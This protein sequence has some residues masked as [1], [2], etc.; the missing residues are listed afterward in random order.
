MAL[1]L[2][3]RM[4][5]RS[6]IGVSPKLTFLIGARVHWLQALH[7]WRFFFLGSD[8]SLGDQQ[9]VGERHL[10]LRFAEILELARPCL[11]STTGHYRVEQIALV[12]LLIVEKNVCATG[13]GSAM[14]VVSMI[15]R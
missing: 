9:A 3:P 12:N 5:S 14:P 1:R 10:L 11:A 6:S 4:S 8:V 2:K 13:A 7:S 15:T